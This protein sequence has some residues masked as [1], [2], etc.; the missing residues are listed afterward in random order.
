M[1]LVDIS[2]LLLKPNL[3]YSG[4][5]LVGLSQ[6][7]RCGFEPNTSKDVVDV[8]VSL[9]SIIC[10]QGEWPTFLKNHIPLISSNTIMLT[11]SRHVRFRASLFLCMPMLIIV[12]LTN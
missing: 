7:Y 3:G 6:G 1:R 2:L 8:E 9:R 4:I 11:I 10:F 12:I 5:L